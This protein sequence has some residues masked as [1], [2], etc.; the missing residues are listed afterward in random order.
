MQ[1]AANITSGAL[2]DWQAID[3]KRVCRTVKNL[4]QRIFRASRNSDLTRVRSLQRLMLKS[5]ANAR[6]SVRRVTQ[7][8]QGHG[9][10]TMTPVM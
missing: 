5:R 3:W 6:E 1:P 7:M 8:N 4:R 2:V 10:Y 9:V